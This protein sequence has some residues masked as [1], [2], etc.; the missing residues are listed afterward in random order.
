MNIGL[1]DFKI[2]NLGAR[3]HL[4][5]SLL[6]LLITD[7]VVILNIPFLRE[8]ITFVYFTFVPGILILQ[9]FKLFKLKFTEKIVLSIGISVSSLILVGLILNLF[10]PL[11]LKPLSLIPVLVTLNLMLIV[12]LLINYKINRETGINDFYKIK[13]NIKDKLLSPLIF[14]FI[15]PFMTF[16]GTY[17]MNTQGNNIILLLML[18]LIPLYILLL[19][20][21]DKIPVITYPIA[22]WMISLGL[23]LM[24]GLTSNHLMGRDVHK[25]FYCFQLTLGSYHWDISNFYDSFNACLSITI[26]PV[27]YKVLSNI[28]SEYVFKVFYAVIGSIIPLISFN[29]FRRYL[30]NRGA[31]FASL[32]IIFMAFF[33]ASMGSVRQLIALVFFFLSIMVLF[34]TK[35]GKLPKKVLLLVFLISIILSHYGTAYFSLALLVPIMAIPFLKSL[36]GRLSGKKNKILFTN[37]DIIILF[38]IFVSIWYL[39]VAQ[40]ELNSGMYVINKTSH[41]LQDTGFTG[42]THGTKDDMI[43]AMLGMGITS[44]PNLISA[45][46]HDTV[47][48]VIFIGFLTLLKS[49]RAGKPKLDN[50]FFSGIVISIIL[51]ILLVIIPNLSIHYPAERLFIQ[52]LI[53]LA[54]LLVIGAGKISNIIKKPRSK[55]IILL[56]LVISLFSCNTYL[57]YHFYGI[58]YSPYY[59]NGGDLRDEYYVY[60]QEIIAAEWLKHNQIN[61]FQIY[62]DGSGI[63]RLL[64]GRFDL[65]YHNVLVNNQKLKGYILLRY[66][67]IYKIILFKDPTKIKNMSYYEPIISS[68][69]LIYNNGRSEVLIRGMG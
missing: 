7:L 3:G 31:F 10:Y 6:T 34:D 66:I 11:I 20:Y 62:T 63:N 55:Y 12:L 43:L 40:V 23:L 27:M 54:P 24:P 33:T 1:K 21:L 52:S 48:F 57:Q 8:F 36:L 5:L 18:L 42:F 50:K 9:I 26:L 35:M 46:V 69:S 30:G 2:N 59:E 25:E 51:L 32:L 47:F 13:A 28:N 53:F 44:V 61:G 19:T 68:S 37:F 41:V 67:N 16:L 14:A 15:F 65:K 17:L 49:Y 60:D 64:L 22:L 39:L 56:I 38:L 4:I 29:I 58:Q 45:V